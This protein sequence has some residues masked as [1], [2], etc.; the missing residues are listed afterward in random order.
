MMTPIEFLKGIC[1]CDETCNINY[2]PYEY[3]SLIESIH[4]KKAEERLKAD[5]KEM[6]DFFL[7]VGITEEEKAIDATYS[8]W[9]KHIIVFQ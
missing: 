5:I 1:N 6:K 9:K 3:G 8:I 7:A 4:I 2:K